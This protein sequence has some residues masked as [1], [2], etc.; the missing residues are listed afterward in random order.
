MNK[1]R[2]TMM[3]ADDLKRIRI[4]RL[5]GASSVVHAVQSRLVQLIQ[6]V[7]PVQPV[8]PVQERIWVC[9]ASSNVLSL[10]HAF[11]DSFH[12]G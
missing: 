3:H 7:Q 6:L 8:Q 12:L 10:K 5:C 11:L 1:R 9:L 2:S 4:N